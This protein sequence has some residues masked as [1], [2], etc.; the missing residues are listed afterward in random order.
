MAIIL[1][2]EILINQNVE[3]ESLRLFK[4]IRKHFIF[5]SFSEKINKY[6]MKIFKGFFKYQ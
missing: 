3:N 4:G 6:L 5:L 1:L 2:K